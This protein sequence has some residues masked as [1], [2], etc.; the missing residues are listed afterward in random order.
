MIITAR[1]EHMVLSA[2]R[3]TLSGK[4]SVRSFY[5]N[6]ANWHDIPVEKGKRQTLQTLV[7]KARSET[8]MELNFK[9]IYTIYGVLIFFYM[10]WLRIS[11]PI[12]MCSGFF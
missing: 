4:Y 7:G 10:G 8:L 2:L 5:S 12:L 9:A 3:L 11:V 1:N 6:R